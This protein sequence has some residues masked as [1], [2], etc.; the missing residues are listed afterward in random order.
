MQVQLN[1]W[2][3]LLRSE[4]LDRFISAGGAAIKFV[5]SDDPA[6]ASQVVSVVD[7]HARE[8]GCLVAKVDSATVRVH[9]MHELFHEIARQIQWEELAKQVVRRC[10]KEQGVTNI[11]DDLSVDTVAS[12]NHFEPSLLRAEV[13]RSLQELIRRSNDLS[14]DFRYAMLWLCMAQVRS[15]GQADVQPIL[16]WLR[17]DLHLISALKRLLIY[18]KIGRHNARAMLGSLSAW[19]RIADYPGLVLILDIR[20]V[21]IGRRADALEGTLHYTAPA[22][23]DAYEL[24]RQL[25]DSTED[26]KGVLCV[27]V[28][29][30]ELFE[31]ERR[32]VKAYKALYERIWPDVRLKRRPNPLSALATISTGGN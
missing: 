20:Q 14:K 6:I 16:E 25:I 15:D 31:D 30:Q 8:V 24:L 10:Y 5:V 22:A 9:M 28:G 26:L 17:G 32:G 3:R 4:Y 23:M 29:R 19:C 2:L 11:G 12:E 27:V 21:A 7:T 13:R 1:E 18:Q